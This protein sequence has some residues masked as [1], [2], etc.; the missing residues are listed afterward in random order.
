M[1]LLLELIPL[2]GQ[3][4]SQLFFDR[5]LLLY[6]K[7]KPHTPTLPLSITKQMIKTYAHCYF[8]LILF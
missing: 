8:C 5:Q 3:N 7:L 1:F 4:P 6:P 2:R